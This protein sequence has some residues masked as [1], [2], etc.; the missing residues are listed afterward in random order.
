MSGPLARMPQS[1]SE[2]L[3]RSW[4]SAAGER[5]RSPRRSR[6]ASARTMWIGAASSASWVRRWTSK[7][8]P[9]I[10]ML[11]RWKWRF[12]KPRRSS[13]GSTKASRATAP[14][15][16]RRCQASRKE[17]MSEKA[18]WVSS[19]RPA[20]LGRWKSR[21][22]WSGAASPW[23]RR[24]SRSGGKRPPS[25]V[26]D[27]GGI[28]CSPPR[29]L[30]GG[31]AWRGVGVAQSAAA[32]LRRARAA[33]VRVTAPKPAREMKVQWRPSPSYP[34]RVMPRMPSMM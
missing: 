6:S 25:T 15:S 13:R 12:P 21:G 10:S 31:R 8:A 29:R 18:A 16:A 23:A 1:A 11:A 4:S 3:R 2:R 20:D 32:R 34:S 24:W 7:D 19:A 33:M 5:R 26:M 22:R 14:G 27:S 17:R 28:G 9:P 30:G